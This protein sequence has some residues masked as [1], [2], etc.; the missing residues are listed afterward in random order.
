[1]TA[2][3]WL[4]N[5]ALYGAVTG[6]V[7]LGMVSAWNKV[8]T[9]AMPGHAR[10]PGET[11][12][13]MNAQDDGQ[14]SLRAAILRAN[15]AGH[16]V[17]IECR[18][19]RI[20]LQSPLPS[21][22]NASGTTIHA[23]PGQCLLDAAHL[24]PR[25]VI[26]ILAPGSVVS[27]LGVSQASGAGILVR[28]ENVLIEDVS[29]RRNTVGL[30]VA[31]E[32]H[33]LTV[34]DSEFIDNEVGIELTGYQRQVQIHHNHFGALRKAG[35][36]AVR[37][38]PPVERDRH[39]RV[40]EN[41]FEGGRNGMVVINVPLELTGNA[42]RATETAGMHLSGPGMVVR[43]N[44]IE[45]HGTASGIYTEQLESGRLEDNEIRGG[46]AGIQLRGAVDCLV[47]HNRLSHG[48]YGL[49]VLHGHA[50][51]PTLILDN[52]VAH[53]RLDGV[54]VLGASPVIRG[55]ELR[56]NKQAGLRLVD[57]RNESGSAKPSAPF[58]E[59]NDIAGNKIN[60]P[61]RDLLVAATGE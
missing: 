7:A 6:V 55:N 31:D 37:P 49:I 32:G 14:G 11:L 34:R 33:R 58:L 22:A 50:A 35:I 17:R 8:S 1:M 51:R 25:P 36:W 30:L 54:Y 40:A 21:I 9:E 5:L 19:G 61:L 57:Y 29:L 44:R 41:R 48:D 39:G 46:G 16:A 26:E 15:G 20:A 53:N 42:I 38:Y 47:R 60:T 52:L 28:A 59:T 10:Q 18:A 13:V 2:K 12:V 56:D 3:Q 45:I 4:Q 27:G 24:P 43:Q 23:T